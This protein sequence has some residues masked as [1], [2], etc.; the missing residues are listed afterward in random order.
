MTWF[1]AAAIRAIRTIA[2]SM[3]ALIGTDTLFYNLDWKVIIIS[4]L[5]AGFLSFLT[6]LTGLPEVTEDNI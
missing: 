4:S 2:Q 3:I 5:M 6:S 1:R